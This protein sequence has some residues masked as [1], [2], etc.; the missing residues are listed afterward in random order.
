MK[1]NRN[2]D[3]DQQSWKWEGVESAKVLAGEYRTVIVIEVYSALVGP[4]AQFVNV[5]HNVCLH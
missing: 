2:T 4:L 3:I 5:D 1:F